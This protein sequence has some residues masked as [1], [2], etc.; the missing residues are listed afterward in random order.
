MSDKRQKDTCHTLAQLT[1]QCV[2]CGLCLP[3]CPTFQ[4]TDNEAAS[5]RGRVVLAEGIVGTEADN[6]SRLH[7][8]AAH[9]DDC[10]QCQ[11]CE[12]A[13]PSGVQVSE[14]IR[15]SRQFLPETPARRLTR[16]MT[17]TLHS[18]WR[19]RLL[20]TILYV[21]QKSR[22]APWLKP[23]LPVTLQ[24]G[25]QHTLPVPLWP[26]ASVPGWFPHP[27][28]GSRAK[29]VGIL[30][31]CSAELHD[32]INL[33]A[34]VQLLHAAGF[35]AWI[36]AQQNC[37]DA[38]AHHHG[39]NIHALTQTNARAFSNPP[40][41]TQLTT[42]VVLNTGCSAHLEALT[43]K[44][45]TQIVYEDV[46]RF[47][48]RHRHQLRF[49]PC[50]E[51]VFAHRPCTQQHGLAA[52]ADQSMLHLLNQ[53]P[54]LTVLTAATGCCG[55]AGNYYLT[56]PQMSDALAQQWQAAITPLQPDRVLSPNIG[57]SMQWHGLDSGIPVEHPVAF[58]ARQLNT[59]AA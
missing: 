16:R 4:I 46:M 39:E 53:V 22:L 31:G 37:C 26:L 32:A 43:K 12:S 56:Q 41:N 6:A 44:K 45:K 27:S 58:L 52:D 2:K 14:I 8:L 20:A 50:T 51:T 47:L 25:L 36:P 15:L 18:R 23:L 57:C 24:R 54:G 42:V 59:R 49:A 5:P 34:V 7:S 55:A 35:N 17:A 38:L 33:P 30:S 29:T 9:I 1:D 19:R 3:A 10:L 28:K 11:A 21:V 40:E 48:S 13:C